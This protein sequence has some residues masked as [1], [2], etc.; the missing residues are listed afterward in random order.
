MRIIR[1]SFGIF[2]MSVL[3]ASALTAC[4]GGGGDGDDGGF[5]DTSQ[6]VALWSGNARGVTGLVVDAA[7]G[8]VSIGTLGGIVISSHAADSAARPEFDL[9]RFVRRDVVDRIMAM[10][11][12][13]TLVPASVNAMQVPPSVGCSGGGTVS[14]VF[15]D[16]DGD[17][18]ISKGDFLTLNFVGCV[19]AGL[20]LNGGATVGILALTGSP[21]T[22]PW[23]VGFRLNLNTLT[24]SDN[25]DLVSIVGTLDTTVGNEASG[26]VVDITTELATGSGTSSSFLHYDEGDDFTEI[27][28]YSIHFEEM[29]ND[30]FVVSGQGKL[31][32]TYIAGT[33]TFQTTEDVTGNGFDVNDPSAGKVFIVGATNSSVLLRIL[34]DTSLAL[35]VD[36]DGGGF[37]SN[38]DTTIASSWDGIRAAA[39]A[40]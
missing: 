12:Q 11:L 29:T 24:A 39:D 37:D 9:P 18:E 14:V 27:S 34:S 40:L 30:D 16:S 31:T 3:A 32:S 25:G 26:T 28:G 8:G 6:P 15:N 20:T 13:G 36:D 4:G 7:L 19:E 17:T 33:V 5:V 35:D 21:P 23:M 38:D 22:L 1:I 10:H 2:F